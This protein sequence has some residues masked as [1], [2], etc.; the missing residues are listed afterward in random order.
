M[1]WFFSEV[2]AQENRLLLKDY[3]ITTHQDGSKTTQ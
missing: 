1:Y 3:F 2:K